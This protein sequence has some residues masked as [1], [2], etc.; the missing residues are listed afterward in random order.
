MLI[1]T[2]EP[3]DQ[4]EWLRLRRALWPDCSEAMH[5]R[6]MED[7]AKSERACAVFVLARG[8]GR[9]GGFAEVSVRDRVDGS[10]SARVAYLEGWF[11]EPDLRGKG[12]GRK[13]VE[14]AEGWATARGL[15]EIASDAEIMNPDSVKAHQALGF[16]ETFRLVHFLKSLHLLAASLALLG[17]S[18]GAN[19]DPGVFTEGAYRD[20]PHMRKISVG[21]CDCGFFGR[22]GSSLGPAVSVK[23]E[24]IEQAETLPRRRP[25]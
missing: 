19:A 21:Q 2:L 10:Q 4:S 15:S 5:A 17:S 9:L 3:H 12:Y 8:P 11:V 7:Y 22:N 6:E 24:L 1:R 13:L 16:R 25:A 20:F 14:A 23:D 18:A